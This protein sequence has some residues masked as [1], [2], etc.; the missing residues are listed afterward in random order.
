MASTAEDQEKLAA[1]VRRGEKAKHHHDLALGEIVSA[2]NRLESIQ[3]MLAAARFVLPGDHHEFET[4]TRMAR[5]EALYWLRRYI[6]AAPEFVRHRITLGE[7][8]AEVD[9]VQE[10]L[11][12][13]LVELGLRTDLGAKGKG[14]VEN[15]PGAQPSIGI[16]S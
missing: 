11:H 3:A 5:E 2:R 10:D 1:L 15:P 8:Q 7:I 9:A 16:T 13:K 4:A 14:P 6:Q 12:L